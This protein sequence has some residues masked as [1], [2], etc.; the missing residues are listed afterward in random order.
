[1]IKPGTVGASSKRQG[2]LKIARRTTVSNLSANV[3]VLNIQR[4]LRGSQWSRFG[5][6][7]A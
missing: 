7:A 4:Y 1:M 5:M 6:G 2:W 3:V